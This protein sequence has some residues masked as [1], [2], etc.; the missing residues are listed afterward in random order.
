MIIRCWG[1]RGSIA[2]SGKEYVKYGGDTTC[3]E[4]RTDDGEV[5]IFDAGT[6]LRSLGNALHQEKIRKLHVLFTHAHWDHLMGFPFFKPLFT[7]GTTLNLCGYPAG[8]PSFRDVIAGLMSAPYFPVQL[9]SEDIRARLRFK[10]LGERPF[11]IGGVRIRPIFLNHPNGG[12]GYRLEEGG[13]S[14]VFLTDNELDFRHA[15]GCS[16]ERYAAFCAGA[17]LLIH[18][19]EYDQKDYQFNRGWGHSLYTDA[20]RL[21]M[22]ASSGWGCFISTAS[23][24]TR[25]SMPW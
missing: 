22:Q 7:S 12:L 2:V 23:V 24:A 19:A 15:G 17:D 16:F 5:I 13:R 1:S 20:V 10:D 14:F 6:G 25:R 21:A 9:D 8:K 18:D 11:K 4:V 3:M